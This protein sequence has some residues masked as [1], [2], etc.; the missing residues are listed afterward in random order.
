MN[1]HVATCNYSHILRP[2]CDII[3]LV[4]NMHAINLAMIFMLRV[5]ACVCTVCVCMCVYV[6]ACV[7]VCVCVCMCVRV[8]DVCVLFVGIL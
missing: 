6:C 1:C 2:Y 3:T 8:C 7:C 4:S 5:Y